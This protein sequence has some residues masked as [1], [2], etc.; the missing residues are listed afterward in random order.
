M[1]LPDCD[2]KSRN[3]VRRRVLLPLKQICY[4]FP[5]K[6]HILLEVDIPACSTANNHLLAMRNRETELSQGSTS[7]SKLVSI[8]N[9]MVFAVSRIPV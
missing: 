4:F 5:Y 7:R 3:S 8:V 6:S 1:I 2:S 9:A